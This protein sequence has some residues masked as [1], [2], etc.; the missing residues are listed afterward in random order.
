M[1]YN[2]RFTE[3]TLDRDDYAKTEKGAKV[4]KDLGA[5]TSVVTVLATVV[6]KRGPKLVK[7]LADL[8]KFI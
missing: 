4:L 7:N 3:Q 2:K 1:N 6:V 8:F 5:I